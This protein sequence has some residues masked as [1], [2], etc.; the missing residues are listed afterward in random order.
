MSLDDQTL[1]RTAVEHG[2]ALK[3]KEYTAVDLAKACLARA[4]RFDRLGAFL[5]LDETNILKQARASDDR[6]AKG[7]SL[8]AL[9][10]IPIAI[11]DN[12]CELDAP[13]TCGSRIL[14]N[15]VAPYD[16]TVIEKLRSA[17]AVLFGRAN[18]DEFAM[19]SSTENSAFHVARNPWDAT[20]VPGGSSGG[21]AVAV[22]AGI[23]PLALGSDTGGSIRQ[24]A[25]FCGV[26]GMKPTYGRVSRYGLV[27][28]ASS[29][30]QIGPFA[31]SVE[32]AA[33][34]LQAISGHDRRDSTSHP[35]D[36]KLQLAPM[37]A[38]MQA[39]D[40]KKLRVGVMLPDDAASREVYDPAVLTQTEAAADYL[41]G[42]GAE[43]VDLRSKLEKYLIPI[44]YI[45]ATAEAS[46]NLSRYD[47]VRYG[48]QAENPKDLKD[49]YVR[50]RTRGFGDEVKRR[51]LLGTFVLSSGYYDAYYKSAQKARRLI[52][53]EY[54][55]FFEKVDV[56][57]SPTSPSTAFPLG[58]RV[59]DPL[60]M[61]QSDILTIAANLTG[62]PAI[63][64]AAGRD[65]RG[66]PVGLQLL[67]AQFTENSLMQ[68]AAALAGAPGFAP[69]YLTITPDGE[70]AEKSAAKKPSGQTSTPVAAAKA[71]KKVAKKAT[72]KVAKK[73]AKKGARP[74]VKKAPAKSSKKAGKKPAKKSKRR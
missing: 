64:I 69:D 65:A 72:K 52:Q 53:K 17:G 23:T 62:T 22:A 61:Y 66:L 67:S 7:Q 73:V 6:R 35:E 26:V 30:D 27:A 63:N 42:Q 14:E 36:K 49:L 41:K 25:A 12:I 34:L 71:T 43:I 16:A 54:A 15:F 70:A 5:S 51:I 37:P 20:R 28:Y 33:L 74:A 31:R 58:D 19:G 3:R 1:L 29:L 4:Q 10:G 39:A 38:K 8:G 45:L 18:M 68:V 48:V 24:P 57:L 47:G 13:A 60:A 2:D 50:S 21:S 40:W 56:I 11:K 46:S 59:G 9:D 55:A 44:Y 32:D